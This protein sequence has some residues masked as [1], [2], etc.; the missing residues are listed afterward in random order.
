MRL[1][2]RDLVW[3]V[4][5]VSIALA[6]VGAIWRREHAVLDRQ[7]MQWKEERAALESG[8]DSETR[9]ADDAQSELKAIENR[10]IKSV[11]LVP[12]VVAT[13]LAPGDT[14][15]FKMRDDGEL[16][17]KVVTKPIADK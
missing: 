17:Y 6:I 3:L 8:K 12:Q 10:G 9:R 5:G 7:R 11:I 15:E 16:D 13:H 1:T 14:A 4:T 2:V